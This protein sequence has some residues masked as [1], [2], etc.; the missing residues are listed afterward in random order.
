MKKKKLIF[1]SFLILL[2]FTNNCLADLQKDLINKLTATKTL[3]F[4][5]KQII[6]EKEETGKCFIKYPMLMKCDYQNLKQKSI[7]SNGRTVAIIKKK[8][9]KIYLYPIG[10]T[11][12]STILKKEKIL[13]L[14]RNSKPSITKTNTIK[15]EFID[16][17]SNK[18]QM[19]FDKN[20]LELKGWET[21]DAYSNNVI[22]EINN[23]KVNEIIDDEFFTI[24]KEEDL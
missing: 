9:K 11:Q 5:F 3:S 4:N 13:A 24:P 6:E 22:F 2:I 12:L 14:I 21:T 17:K 18:L 20:S 8:Y 7:I 1:Q 15:Y 10:K 16:K 19:Y 23:I